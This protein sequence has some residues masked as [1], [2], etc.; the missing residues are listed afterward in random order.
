M[1][2]Q[3]LEAKP[4]AQNANIAETPKTITTTKVIQLN[5]QARLEE[6]ARMLAGDR[7]TPQA[8]EAAQSLMNAAN[9]DDSEEN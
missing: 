3:S 9:N 2:K 7:I 4:L 8:R 6:I 1:E 5:K